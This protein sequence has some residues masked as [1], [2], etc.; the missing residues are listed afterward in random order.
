MIKSWSYEERSF[1][2][3]WSIIELEGWKPPA[4]KSVYR[5]QVLLKRGFS[6]FRIAAAKLRGPARVEVTWLSLSSANTVT[7]LLTKLELRLGFQQTMR[8]ANCSG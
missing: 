3:Q 5:C 7:L 8:M 2:M 6:P 4:P 1:A